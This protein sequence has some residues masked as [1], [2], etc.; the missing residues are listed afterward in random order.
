MIDDKIIKRFVPIE[1]THRLR[2]CS[3]KDDGKTV[4]WFELVN[5][6]YE[7]IQKIHVGLTDIHVKSIV[8]KLKEL[9]ITEKV[10]KTGLKEFYR[11]YE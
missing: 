10:I 2:V 4:Y 3:R 5:K 6:K 7:V 11:K 9:G 8:A 1:S